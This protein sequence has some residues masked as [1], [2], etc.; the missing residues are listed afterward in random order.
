MTEP[1]PGIPAQTSPD[2]AADGNH[3]TPS[4]APTFA[5]ASATTEQNA[6]A[7]AA[8]PQAVATDPSTATET[9]AANPADQEASLV[10]FG[11]PPGAEPAG[12]PTVADRA[13]QLVDRAGD[14][15]S[16]AA[17]K[18]HEAIGEAAE[19]AGEA[20][21][22]AAHDAVNR[23]RNNATLPAARGRTTIANEVVEKVAGIAARE[24]PGVYDLGG[25]VA[26]LFS[27]VRER[28]NLG[29]ESKAQGV[30]VRLEGPAAEITVTIVV[31][32]GFVV[33]SVTDKVREKVIS[34]V[35]ALLQ[36]DVKSVDVVVD[37][38]H[39][40]EDGPVGND[41]ERAHGYS[42]TTE[43]IVVGQ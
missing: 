1:T 29:E 19:R 2:A 36:L 16:E 21:S 41:K 27:S 17:D 24:V 15:I 12:A 11:A 30:A 3:Y 13:N 26:R 14:A 8:T 20:L 42:S 28:L 5:P 6:T 38:I 25:D 23:I 4:S 10:V 18:A 35:E 32:F 22:E 31:E 39:V 9:P 40:D 33:S 7:T 43:A 34:S 37:D